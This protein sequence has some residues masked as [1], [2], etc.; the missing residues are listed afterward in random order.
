MICDGQ[1]DGQTDNFG[2]NIYTPDWGRGGHNNRNP[3]IL[4]LQNHQPKSESQWT[5]IYGSS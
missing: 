2:K 3:K 4:T 1:T 5:M